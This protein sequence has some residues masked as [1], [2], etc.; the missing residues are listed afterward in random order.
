MKIL[1][2]YTDSVTFILILVIFQQWP[3]KL[4]WIATGKK[5]KIKKINPANIFENE[6]CSFYL[7]NSIF[8]HKH[9]IVLKF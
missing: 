8:I 3:K 4:W 6:N 1:L 9:S 7:I 5:I 2:I